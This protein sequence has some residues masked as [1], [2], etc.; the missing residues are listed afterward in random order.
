MQQLSQKLKNGNLQVLE[1]PLP[2]LKKGYVL[3]RNHYSVI[4]AGTEAN[5][6]KAAKKNYIGKAKER[7]QQFQQ[8][9]KSLKTQGTVQTYRTVMKKLDSYSTLGY[10]SAGE[11]ID[12]SSE[13]KGFRVGDMVACGGL[14]ASHS[15]VVSVPV[16]LCVKLRQ[17]A[18]LKL[19]CYNTLGATAL[20]GIRQAD[21][22]LGETCAIIGLGLLGQLTSLL[23]SAAGVRVIGIDIDSEMVDIAGKHCVDLALNRDDVGI[24]ENILQFTGGLGCDGIIITAASDSLDPINFAG[25]ISRKK[26]KIVVVGG[27]P[28]GFDREP[29]FYKKELQVKMS[30]SYGPG[31]YDPEYEEKGIDYPPAYVRWTENRNMQAFQ[32][33]IYSQKVKINYLTTHVYKLEKSPLAYD[34][35]LKKTEP[36][37]GILVE[38]D[39]TKKFKRKKIKIAGEQRTGKSKQEVTIGF[40]GAGSYAQGYLLPNIPKRNRNIQL[41]GVM[42]NSGASSRSVAERFGFE[43]CTSNEEDILENQQINTVFVATRH[44]SHA[45][46]VLKAIKAGKHV[47]VEKPLCLTLDQLQEI[48]DLVMNNYERDTKQILMVGYNRRFAP[49]TGMIK[50]AFNQGP[51]AITYRIN[52]GMIPAGSWIQDSEAGG[53]RIIGEACHFVDFLTY[54]TGSIPISVYA[55]SMKNDNVFDDVLNVSLSYKNGSIGNICFFSNGDKSLPKERVE[56]YADGCTAVLD[57]FKTL[58][59]HASKKRKVK[60]LINQNKGQK[61]EI[62]QFIAALQSGK[63]ELIP[64]DEIFVTSLV[65]FKITDSIRTGKCLTI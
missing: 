36:F 57:D 20:Q 43:F 63:T 62:E 7:P 19:A 23:L 13:T 33:L 45:P 29:N 3:V 34:L 60:K 31:R 4:S 42:T 64:F 15:E 48:S 41:K 46:Y 25:E 8:V 32:E 49:L 21:H 52:A 11:V 56:I 10:S 39:R 37:L 18:D 28:T 6:V 17:D 54:V 55:A 24:K 35:M 65:T 5:T 38:Y 50:K 22:R 58:T 1:V 30:C 14:T 16:N 2:I 44:D 61:N 51:M 40:I 47:F 9:M 27:V 59:I 26:G 53:G 12:L